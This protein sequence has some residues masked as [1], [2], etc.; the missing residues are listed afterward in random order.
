MQSKKGFSRIVVKAGSSLLSSKD[1]HFTIEYLSRIINQVNSLIEDNKEVVL[2][3]SGA[4]AC[5]M[6]LLK[7]KKR[8]K[9]IAMLQAAAAIGQSELM[10]IYRRLLRPY[11]RMCAQL[12]LTWEDFEDRKRYLNVRKTIL[13]LLRQKVVPIINENDTVSTDEIRFG[14]NDKLSSLVANL[15][16]ADLLLILSD[17]DGL[18]RLPEKEVIRI[19]EKIT[20]QISRICT[21]TD[22]QTC[23][24][25]MSSKIGAIKIAVSSGIPSIV[26]NGRSAD[27][28]LKAASGQS[29]GT[30]F[31]P[32]EQ[33]L[34]ARERWIAYGA[35]P[36]GLIIVDDGA[37]EALVRNGKSLLSVGIAAIKGGFLKDDLVGI[38]D[39]KM[40][41]FA[42]GKVNFSAKE[43]EAHKGLRLKKEVIHRDNLVLL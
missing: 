33:D 16:G 20:P 26:A 27:A 22:K 4:I 17:V 6:S 40:R 38:A 1:N 15:I 19:V 34:K 35:R 41:E 2:V 10:G 23:V 13:T 3:S 14:D 8:P 37:K 18:Y 21:N 32:K 31:L 30:L 28:I 5:G 7:I 39:K 36:K 43:L 11:N 42:R 25:G 24:G 29:E 9:D 12:L